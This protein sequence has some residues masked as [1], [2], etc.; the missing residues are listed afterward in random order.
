VLIFFYIEHPNGEREQLC[1]PLTAA[2]F[3][4]HLSA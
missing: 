2:L 3:L 1:L 4:L